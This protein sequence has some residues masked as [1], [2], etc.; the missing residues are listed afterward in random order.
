MQNV[1]YDRMVREILLAAQPRRR[2]QPIDVMNVPDRLTPI[3]FDLANDGKPENLAGSTA[4]LFL[5]VKLECA[6]C[7]NH[8]HAE[9]TQDQFWSY[10]AFLAQGAPAV[11]RG[12]HQAAAQAGEEQ[13]HRDGP[14]H[15]RAGDEVHGERRDGEEDRDQ[16]QPGHHQGT[17]QPG[18]HPAAEQGRDGRPAANGV[19]ASPAS[20]AE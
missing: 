4:R 2:G 3:A 11:R 9:W 7:H 10:A 16:H 17:A 20:R 5:A 19:V 13:R 8:P 14:G 1:G 18:D 15:V 6:Q 12:D